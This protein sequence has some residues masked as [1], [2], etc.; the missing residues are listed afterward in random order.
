MASIQLA[1]VHWCFKRKGSVAVTEEIADCA[2][3]KLGVV[4]AGT[5]GCS[6]AALFLARG[7]RVSIYDPAEGAEHRAQEFID[8]AWPNLL[9]LG[10]AESDVPPQFEFHHSASAAI[11]GCQFVQESG[12]ENIES[13]R[14]LLAEMEASLEPGAIVSS[15][16]SGIMPSE[17]QA[18]RKSPERYIVGHPFNPPHLIPLVEVVGGAATSDAVIEQTM[19][20]YKSLGK[21][22]IRINKEVP[23][24]VANRMQAALYREAIH[25]VL[26]G[27]ATPAQVDDAV[28]YGP[29]LRWAIMGPHA[30]HS[31]GGGPGG[32]R[33]L[34]EHIGPGIGA[35]WESLGE[36]TITPESI[37]QLVSAY[38]ADNPP[39]NEILEARRD[40]L[41]LGMLTTIQ[42]LDK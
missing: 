10:V 23:G 38:E 20:F 9:Q 11:A 8:N 12:P 29:G 30:S 33:H 14:Q 1:E 2:D 40:K 34:L 39:S 17:I 21:K 4:G 19:A 25:L 32:M 27:V 18:G 37:E 28:A 36:P 42:K 22:A 5:I 3:W 7:Y 16:T 6:W 26:E 13:K 24:H 35:W 41:L 31:L 15:S